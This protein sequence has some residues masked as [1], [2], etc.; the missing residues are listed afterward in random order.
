MSH[1]FT[2][3]LG[4]IALALA[5]AVAGCH[6]GGFGLRELPAGHLVHKSSNTPTPVNIATVCVPVAT[7]A[8]GA[9]AVLA[10]TKCYVQPSNSSSSPGTDYAVMPDPNVGSGWTCTAYTNLRIQVASG[11]A[12]TGLTGTVTPSVDGPGA[13]SGAG[14]IRHFLLTVNTTTALGPVGN[15]NNGASGDYYLVGD[16]KECSPAG[17]CF[18]N[19]YNIGTLHARTPIKIQD[20]ISSQGV[21]YYIQNNHQV[22]VAGQPRTITAGPGDG[23]SFANNNCTWSVPYPDHLVAQ[24]TPD[25]VATAASI[26]PATPFPPG[27]SSTFYWTHPDPPSGQ[28]DGQL[29]VTCMMAPGGVATPI[30][31]TSVA[32]YSNK[33]PASSVLAQYGT[34]A[35]DTNY[36]NSSCTQVTNPWLHYGAPCGVPGISSTLTVTTDKDETGLVELFQLVDFNY[37]YFLTNGT[38]NNYFSGQSSSGHE[39]TCSDNGIPYPPGA[40]AVAASAT[41][42]GGPYQDS[43]GLSLLNAWKATASATLT[44]YYMYQS[45]V[46]NSIWVTLQRLQWTFNAS[47]VDGQV[48][49][50]K[51]IATTFSSSR[52]SAGVTIS[53]TQNDL[54]LAWVVVHDVSSPGQVI[55]PPVGWTQLGSTVHDYGAAAGALFYKIAGNS[56]PGSYTFSWSSAVNQGGVEVS[57]YSGVSATHPID[58]GSLNRTGSST[59]SA[60]DAISPTNAGELLASFISGYYPATA[61]SQPALSSGWASDLW[62]AAPRFNTIASHNASGSKSLTAA[63]ATWSSPYYSLDSIVALN[64][65]LGWSANAGTL[66]APTGGTA[67]NELPTWTCQ[68]NNR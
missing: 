32:Y 21:R 10:D 15:Y 59:T 8:P 47:A 66:V 46:P 39:T 43:P 45:S 27:L 34:V 41:T 53:P 24:Y 55:T 12:L 17:S 26:L 36:Q 6:G 67:Y 65:T 25:P 61:A 9:G 20:D 52:S 28:P 64:P 5:A 58:I 18:T 51:S 1:R 44:D 13:C 3:R 38:T 50:V 2:C 40:Q 63:S 29:A 23:E 62:T 35:A 19:S 56:E 42:Y 7:A 48:N 30:P 33:V 37:T 16:M 54:L 11:T 60:T 4:I 68:E 49:P 22:R 57:E 31:V 14:S